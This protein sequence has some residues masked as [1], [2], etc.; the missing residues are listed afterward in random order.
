M[1]RFNSMILPKDS[2]ISPI[3]SNKNYQDPII[4]LKPLETKTNNKGYV[5]KFNLP[6]KTNV[7]S[8]NRDANMNKESLS[9]LKIKFGLKK[10]KLPK[11]CN[12]KVTQYFK[13]SDFY[14]K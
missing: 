5:T 6:S 7:C 14:Y 2:N 13:V 3:R 9:I 8:T 10:E 12:S 4:K 11:I 1:T